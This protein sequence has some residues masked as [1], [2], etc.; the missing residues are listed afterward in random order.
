M[1]LPLLLL[2]SLAMLT[3]ASSHISHVH[4]RRFATTKCSNHTN[5]NATP[6]GPIC[7]HRHG[8]TTNGIHKPRHSSHTHAFHGHVPL[9]PPRVVAPSV[10]WRIR[11]VNLTTVTV[12]TFT[13]TTS[14][15][16]VTTTLPY[17][18][19]PGV[20]SASYS[21]ANLTEDVVTA[22]MTITKVL[23][24][25]KVVS[26]TDLMATTSQI[27]NTSSSS[28]YPSTTTSVSHTETKVISSSAALQSSDADATMTS[29][30]AYS[31]ST[32]LEQTS[33]TSL[34][35]FYMLPN[36]TASAVNMSDMLS[37]PT[38]QLSSAANINPT[39]TMLLLL[40]VFL[41]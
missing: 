37:I 8:I 14:L 27:S 5:V 26:P 7:R 4:A 20:V 35:V 41:V 29:M 18:S 10:Q 30:P 31:T 1:H 22:T 23:T 13:T 32:S 25:T 21:V 6:K 24:Q 11:V 34:Q 15:T 33:S 12:T 28:I 40:L 16:L 17:S 9:A 36:A 38:F 39:M 3:H 19:V 2:I